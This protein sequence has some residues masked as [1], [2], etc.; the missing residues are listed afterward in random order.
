MSTI[1]D[2]NPFDNP[3]NGTNSADTINAWLGNDTVHGGSGNDA[4]VG[5]GASIASYADAPGPVSVDIG[6]GTAT[7][8]GTDTLSGIENVVGSPF[9]DHLGGRGPSVCSRRHRELSPGAARFARRPHGGLEVRVMRWVDKLQLRLR[10]L[11]RRPRVE[12]E[13][14][15]VNA[16]GPEFAVG[17]PEHDAI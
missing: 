9:A 15:D 12:Q 16:W 7:G 13:L 5:T 11:L 17:E 14:D 8:D 1:Q 4:L 3:I 6:A 2:I 10:S